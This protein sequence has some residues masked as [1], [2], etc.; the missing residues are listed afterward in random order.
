MMV[1]LGAFQVIEG[2]VALLRRGF[3]VVAPQGLVV[4]VDYNTWGWVHLIIGVVVA[5]TGLGVLAG[6]TW[7]RVVGVVFAGLSAIVNL[8]FFP[9]YPFWAAIVIVVDIVVIYALCVHGRQILT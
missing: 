7:A 8:A 3:Y 6:R 5:A 1:L 2:L 9:A 4:D